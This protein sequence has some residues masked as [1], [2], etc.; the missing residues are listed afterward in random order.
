MSQIALHHSA[1]RDLE[2]LPEYLQKLGI[3]QTVIGA[4]D[5]CT[6]KDD[7]RISIPR[8]RKIEK[9]LNKQGI[10]IAATTIGWVRGHTL[11][12]D[13]SEQQIAR[14]EANIDAMG[15]AGLGLAQLFVMIP[16]EAKK[17]D[18][19]K[20]WQR[21]VEI[22]SRI[23]KAA[24]KA[25][26][27]IGVHG[28]QDTGHLITG[29]GG[30]KKLLEAVDS[31]WFGVTLCTGCLAIHGSDPANCIRSLSEKLFF[32]HA[33]D[34]VF[35][36]KGQWY[37]VNLGNGELDYPAIK[38]AIKK[39]KFTG[40]IQPEHLGHVSFETNEEITMARAVGFLRGLLEPA[41]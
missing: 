17:A 6:A 26:V 22:G 31:K 24:R 8:L 21:A 34:I 37:D 14:I 41:G 27:R 19:K 35:P 13:D 29:L 11:F 9:Q 36:K 2:S 30:Y 25:K 4:P 23:A 1:V 38:R 40:P 18:R 33:R 15:K 32:L 10:A 3:T 5:V 12:G 28:S 39:A 16:A 7:W 20:Q